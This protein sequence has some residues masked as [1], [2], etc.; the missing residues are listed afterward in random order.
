MEAETALIGT[1][2]TVELDAVT[3]V[4]LHLTLVVNPGYAEGEDTVR[5][6]QTLHNLGLL[7]LG[8]LVVH[9]LD[10]F[11]N[12]LNSLQILF[13]QRVL[14]LEACHDV[15]CFHYKKRCLVFMVINKKEFASIPL[16]M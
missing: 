2:G 11:Q 9:I 6:Y 10:G 8:M 12:F 4:G 3:G 1:D 13:L 7:K 15:S 5:L 14:G 16:Q